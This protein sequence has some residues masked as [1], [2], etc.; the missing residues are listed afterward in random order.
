MSTL[1]PVRRALLSVSDKTGLV[2]FARAL[3]ELGAEIVSTGGTA[4][5]LADAGLDA[6]AIER[7]TGFPEIMDGRV[8]TLHPAVHGAILACR[9][10]GAHKE[11]MARHG[12][13]PIDL[14][15]VNLYP[16]ERTAASGAGADETI[17]E[18]DVGGP[19]MIR[20]A[21]KNHRWVAVVTD[22]AQYERIIAEMREQRG[23][24]TLALRTELAAAA[25]ARTAAYDAAIA[26]WMARGADRDESRL[27]ERLA[28]SYVRRALL[29]YGENPH[30]RAAVYADPA[31]SGPSLATARL[32]HGKPLSYNNLADAA[33]AMRLAQD[34][35]AAFPGARAAVIVKHTNPCGAA[36]AE[37][38]AAA[39]DRAYEG[40]PLAAY[41]GVLAMSSAIDE[42]AAQRIADG[43]RFL[44]VIVAPSFADRAA[45]ALGR[46]WANVRLLV[47]ESAGGGAIGPALE[48]RTI[49]GG[50]LAQERDATIE[51]P[52]AWT[53]AAGPPPGAAA[54]SDALLAWIA[55]KHLTSNAIA[56]AAGGRLAGAG[57]GQMDRVTACRLA[58]EKAGPRARGAAAASDAFFPF[59]DGPRV[60]IDAGVA[61]IVH[62]GGSKRD[63]ET[64]ALC[65]ERGVTCLLTGVRHFRH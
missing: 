57:A 42:E 5:A 8:K 2:P 7:V 32:L 51:D 14:V 47:P 41:G 16:F 9:G 27:P 38:A 17:E 19:A 56:L 54:R 39:F 30:Q 24:T 28:L 21:A 12:I 37:S 1:V 22:P 43:Q 55:A 61:C 40:D 46:R 62:P 15:C 31:A 53:L 36:V 49:P 23:A 26:A 6:I 29:R 13:A 64:F 33:S 58:V 60:L 63:D 52:A 65:A 50:L 35:A 11:A 59:S 45:E 20:A 34:L 44:E 18:I 25:F 3:R 10:E 4:R 48:H